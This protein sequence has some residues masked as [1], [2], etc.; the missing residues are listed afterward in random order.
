M[1]SATQNTVPAAPQGTE[2]GKHH[3]EGQEKQK[4]GMKGGEGTGEEKGYK[5]G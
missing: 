2:S 1:G 3:A 5:A 4:K